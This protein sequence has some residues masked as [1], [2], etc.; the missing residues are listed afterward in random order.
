MSF[1]EKGFSAASEVASN[2]S[3]SVGDLVSSKRQFIIKQISNTF[4]LLVI[5]LV[6][7][8]FDFLHLKFHYEYLMDAN[9]WVNIAVKVVA[10]ICA[11]N[12][13]V[14]FIIDDV[15]KRNK[16]LINLKSQYEHLN[17]LKQEDF[18]DFIDEYNKQQRIIAY[19]NNINHKIYLLNKHSKKSDR[20]AYTRN[21]E[22]HKKGYA[23]KRWEL[24]QMK[25]D[26]FILANIDSLDVHY[27]DVDPAIFELEINGSE[28]IVTNKVTGSVGKGRLI[29]SMST[30]FGVIA[31][32]IIISPI[33]LQP[34]KQ[35]FED[36][37]VAAVNYA[38]KIAS[39]IGIIIW[40]FTRG[41]LGTHKIVSTQLTIPLAERVKILKD[42]YSWR[43]RNGKDV[44][45]YYLNLFIEKKEEEVIEIT[46]EQFNNLQK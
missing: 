5:L 22:D 41:V 33:G 11:Y 42:Y 43:K 3:D 2:L 44:P 4:L 32:S 46:E 21:P 27:R 24:E 8:C 36:G 31:F 35:E 37:V 6:F 23:R 15:I 17:E 40:Q 29:A 10:D 39:D 9:Y 19:K 20:V 30:M 25:T 18:L 45:Q 28:K 16:T 26:E 38:M 12:I 1:I 14:N 34:N 13:G 7:G